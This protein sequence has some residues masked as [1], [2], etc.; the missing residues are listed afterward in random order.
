M[1]KDLPV[2]ISSEAI[3]QRN[4]TLAQ[5]ILNDFG[6]EPFLLLSLLTGSFI[7]CADLSR[8]I[9][10]LGGNPIV[11]FLSVSSYGSETVSSGQVSIS[12][13]KPLTFPVQRVLVLDDILDTGLTLKSVCEFL[14][15]KTSVTCKTVVLLDKPSRR[16]VDFAADY[17][18]FTI[19]NHFV[20]GYGLDFNEQYRSL[21][22]IAI[23][24]EASK[25]PND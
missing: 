1:S 5:E 10:K 21:P 11:E 20:V 22:H 6:N 8:E 15:S 3:H 23:Y 4:Q 12:L 16:E 25:A 19:D 7:F 2:L 17:V 13:I 18:G 9:A 14:F 24:Q